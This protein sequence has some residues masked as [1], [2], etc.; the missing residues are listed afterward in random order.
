MDA[1][2][3]ARIAGLMDA[4]AER[5]VRA[6]GAAAS[7]VAGPY[8]ERMLAAARQCGL[9]GDTAAL[10]R[11]R[12]ELRAIAGEMA[13]DLAGAANTNSWAARHNGFLRV[14]TRYRAC[15]LKY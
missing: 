11:L 12:R 9:T 14:S 13:H 7:R 4:E 2:E 15:I 8:I 5:L 10:A 3:L 6:G 1:K